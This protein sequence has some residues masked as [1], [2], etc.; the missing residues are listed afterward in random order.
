MFRMSVAQTPPHDW[1]LFSIGR[2]CTV[3]GLTQQRGE[4][5][6]AP[7]CAPPLH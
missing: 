3:C 5:D 2:R 1:V 7:Q 6:D 4:F